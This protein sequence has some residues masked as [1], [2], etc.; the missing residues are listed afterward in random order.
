ML[1]HSNELYAFHHL[2]SFNNLTVTVCN[3][4]E[5]TLAYSPHPELLIFVE[6]HHTCGAML[7]FFESTKAPPLTH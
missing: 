2:K 4:C 5:K 6:E 1:N 3:F 7:E